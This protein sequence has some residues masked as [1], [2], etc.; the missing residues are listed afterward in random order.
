LRQMCWGTVDR[1]GFEL[2]KS[3]RFVWSNSESW[4]YICRCWGSRAGR[5]R[6]DRIAPRNMS[7]EANGSWDDFPIPIS[8]FY[9]SNS[10]RSSNSLCSTRGASRHSSML[11][12][13]STSQEI[14]CLLW[15]PRIKSLFTIVHYWIICKPADSGLQSGNQ[16]L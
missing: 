14:P 5:C 4:V 12:S 9:F 6:L 15:N 3:W 1:I 13:S 2:L 16:F 11:S 8:S 10:E 7:I